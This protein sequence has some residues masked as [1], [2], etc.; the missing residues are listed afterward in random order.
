MRRNGELSLS[1]HDNGPGAAPPLREGV[2]LTNTRARLERLYGPD[3]AIRLG[4][5]PGGGFAVTIHIPIRQV[6]L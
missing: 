2:G 1:V 3:A 5:A 4:P 6:S